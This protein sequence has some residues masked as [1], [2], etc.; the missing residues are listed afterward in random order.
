MPKSTNS[1][2]PGALAEPSA[3]ESTNHEL[4]RARADQLFRAA[5]ECCRQH[6]RYSHLT[7]RGVDDVELK[8]VFEV[9]ALCDRLLCESGAAYEKASA[10][11]HP[12]GPDDEWWHLANALWMAAREYERRHDGCDHAAR[13]VS[14][15]HDSQKF[16]KLQIDYE[17]EAS[18]LLS[19]KQA[20]EAYRKARPEAVERPSWR[21]PEQNG[22]Q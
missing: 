9:V 21:V 6:E 11:T 17:L 4:V 19:L 14:A 8:G 12:D 22:G 7:E 18:A 5:A 1:S 13:R 2:A 3:P 15:A 10:R 20:V 16:A